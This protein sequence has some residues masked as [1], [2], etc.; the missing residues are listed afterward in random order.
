MGH[1]NPKALSHLLKAAIGVEFITKELDSIVCEQCEL[2]NWKQKVSR[3]PRERSTI[4]F[5]TVSWDVMYMKDGLGGEKRVLDAIDDYTYGDTITVDTPQLD[6]VINKPA[7]IA[8]DTTGPGVG[9]L[10]SPNLTPEPESQITTG[11]TAPGL[12]AHG[13]SPVLVTGLPQI[14]ASDTVSDTASDTKYPRGTAL[15]AYQHLD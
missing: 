9:G 7:T 4:P 3:A 1:P 5:D 8:P 6:P 13:D 10:L 15:L 11:V 2:T 14:D 12:P